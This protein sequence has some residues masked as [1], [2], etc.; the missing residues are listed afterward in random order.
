[1]TN[2]T[3]RRAPRGT[4]SEAY[5]IERA[6]AGVKGWAVSNISAD[7]LAGIRA[8]LRKC[9]AADAAM[10]GYWK[11]RIVHTVLTVEVIPDEGSK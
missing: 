1:M 9:R 2:T 4:H 5:S 11:Y 6:L 7:T 3:E 10:G 8:K